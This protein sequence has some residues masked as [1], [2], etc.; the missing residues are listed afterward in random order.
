M[1]G[2]ETDS[3]FR[4]FSKFKGGHIRSERHQLGRCIKKNIFAVQ[5]SLVNWHFAN[6]DSSRNWDETLSTALVP[7]KL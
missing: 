2:P 4:T 3:N 7:M 5:R 6:R 1:G